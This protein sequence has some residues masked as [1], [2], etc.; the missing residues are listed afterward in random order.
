LT[1]ESPP[2]EAVESERKL[3]ILI[4]DD[5]EI[6][7]WGLRVVLSRQ[8]WV[9]RCIGARTADEA[10]AMVRR[11]EPH[12]AIVDLMLGDET[13]ADVAEQIRAVSPR[14]RVLLMSGAGRIGVRAAASLGAS[15]FIA[16][17]LPA[18]EIA[19]AVLT[20][21]RGGTTFTRPPRP[22]VGDLSPRERDVLA[23]VAKG[24]TNREIATAVELSPHTVKEHLSS[25]YRKLGARNRTDALQRAQHR[26]LIC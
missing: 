10:L 20:V 24:A 13:G 8:A 21:G 7:H 12:V 15:G 19:Q 5:H 11:Y 6:V 16:K 17:D 18:S 22:G 9:S 2:C 14:T 23:L 3:G 25:L 1:T 26:G 4:V